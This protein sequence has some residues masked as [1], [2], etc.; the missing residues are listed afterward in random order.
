LDGVTLTPLLSLGFEQA[1]VDGYSET[2]SDSTTMA[3]GR[4]NR[5]MLVGSIG[6]RAET[7]VTLAGMEWSPSV[8]VMFNDDFRAQKRYILANVSGAPVQF[9]EPVAEPGRTW[10]TLSAALGTSITP[11][12][13]L[14]ASGGGSVGQKGAS[15]S[16]GSIGVSYQF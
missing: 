3:F 16:F 14:S 13:A 7:S 5:H 8:S 12:L 4:Q 10:T 2:Q 6:G 11:N 1:T 9:A 15:S